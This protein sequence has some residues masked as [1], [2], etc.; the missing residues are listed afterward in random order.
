MV[1]LFLYKCLINLKDNIV[2]GSASFYYRYLKLNNFIYFI[3][4][5][6]KNYFILNNN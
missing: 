3:K 1:K 5:M 6:I 2:V 4:T